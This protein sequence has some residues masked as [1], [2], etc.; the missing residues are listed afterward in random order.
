MAEEEVNFQLKGID[1][2]D[3]FFKHPEVPLAKECQY[4]FD[5]K[6]EHKING[7]EK[8]IIVAPT[9][10]VRID[11]SDLTYGRIKINIFYH[12]QNLDDFIVQESKEYNIPESFIT[13]LNSISIS[14]ARGLMF[15]IF[16]GTFLNNAILPII[17]PANFTKE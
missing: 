1:I 14:T 8:L 7:E 4:N 16:K 15:S 12:I 5:I 17:N 2:V 10:S 13:T 6:I 11:N 9:I 3:V